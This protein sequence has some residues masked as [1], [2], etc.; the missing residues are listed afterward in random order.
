MSKPPKSLSVNLCLS[1]T[2]HQ[3]LVKRAK[4]AKTNP[5]LFIDKLLRETV[6]QAEMV[7]G[8][9]NHGWSNVE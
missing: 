8:I 3:I 4:E 9:I 7:D 5:S 6:T 2:A 1:Y